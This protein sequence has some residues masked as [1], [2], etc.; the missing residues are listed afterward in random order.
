MSESKAGITR[1]A[2]L[3]IS[4]GIAAGGATFA[5]IARGATSET[6]LLVGVR[7]VHLRMVGEQ[8]SRSA[9]RAIGAQTVEIDLGPDMACQA[10]FGSDEPLSIATEDGA[11]RLAESAEELRIFAY[12][13]RNRFDESPDE[14]VKQVVHV[15][16][17]CKHT[18]TP[19]IRLDVVPRRIKDRDEFLKFAIETCKRLVKGTEETGVRL[20]IE[21]HGNTTNDF[22]FT[23]KLFD[24]VGSERI[25]LTLDTGNFYWFGYPLSELYGIYEKFASRAFH[26]HCK[27]IAY[28]KEQ[29]NEKRKM[30]FEYGKYNC[31]VY[32]GDIDFKRVVAILRKA[33]YTGDLCVENES[34]SK[35]PEAARR[36][37][38]AKEI[39]FLKELA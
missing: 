28:P 16:R 6:K 32:E 22:T 4:A 31:P 24:G 38:L 30:G 33:N 17:M 39:A 37:V 27:S 11:K 20:G 23:E 21:N 2:F 29:R 7:D 15:A 26:T 3:G 13:M 14:E 12:C 10:I 5:Q 19:V 35:F 1:R 8:N 25:G 18:N 9:M 34:L 36:D